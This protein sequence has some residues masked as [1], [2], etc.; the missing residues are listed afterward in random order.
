MVSPVKTVG[1]SVWR[2]ATAKGSDY[3][4]IVQLYGKR[5]FTLQ[6]KNI[7]AKARRRKEKQNFRVFVSLRPLR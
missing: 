6:L 1:G 2:P 3:L 7:N 5:P 4:S